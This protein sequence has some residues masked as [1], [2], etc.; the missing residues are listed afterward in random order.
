VIPDRADWNKPTGRLILSDITRG[1]NMTGVKD[2][3]ITKLLVLEA[4]PKPVNF[5]GGPAPLTFLGTFNL[6]RV[7]GTVPVEPDGS[8]FMEVPA[9]RSLVLVALDKDDRSVKRM[10]SFVSVMPGETMSCA[11]CH[12]QRTQTPPPLAGTLALRRKP[13]TIT[14]FAQHPAVIDFPRDVQPV[15]NSHCV[16]CHSYDKPD[17]GI[18]LEGDRGS[19]YSQSYW[20]IIAADLVADGKNAYGNRPPRSIGSSASRLM[21]LIDGSHYGVKLPEKDWRAVWLWIESGAVYAGT[22]ASLGAGMVGVGIPGKG[23]YEKRCGQ[24]HAAPVEGQKMPPGKVALPADA[25]QQTRLPGRAP[26]ERVVNPSMIRRAPYALYNLT[27]PE[28]SIVLLAPLAQDAGGWGSCK[29]IKPDGNFGAAV[30]VFT[31]K[32]DPDYRRMLERIT[33]SR[34]ELN[35]IKRFDMP[36]F[37]PNA[38]YLR[39]MKRYGILPAAFDPAKD[40]F[41]VFEIDQAY[42]RSLWFVPD[43]K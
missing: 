36:G 23:V 41:D 43:K 39:E 37:V 26:H 42:W 30:K 11:G 35:R 17:G 16:R 14:P 5:S 10:Q 38:Q 15:L 24:C 33:A 20:T 19:V 18:V 1:R 27:R 2:G 21:K 40:K 34:D 4:L 13:S 9:N 22:Y 8:A 3:E 32:D 7:L 6:E 28:K 31:S 25:S 12:E 29:E